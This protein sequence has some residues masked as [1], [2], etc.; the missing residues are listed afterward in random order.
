MDIID[1]KGILKTTGIKDIKDVMDIED[2]A[3]TIAINTYVHHLHIGTHE[4]QIWGL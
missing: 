3:D 1:T 4:Q 2:F